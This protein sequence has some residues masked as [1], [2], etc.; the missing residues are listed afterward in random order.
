MCVK[1]PFTYFEV[2]F[3]HTHS[4]ITFFTQHNKTL[5][6]SYQDYN[7]I[8]PVEFGNEKPGKWYGR[9]LYHGDGVCSWILT[10]DDELIVRSSIRSAHKDRPNASFVNELDVKLKGSSAY[11]VPLLDEP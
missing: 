5:Q 4:L 1:L 7:Y 8:F 6:Y 11:D 10:A 9:A 3:I 2:F